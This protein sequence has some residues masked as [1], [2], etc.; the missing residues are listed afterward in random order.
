MCQ[1]LELLRGCELCSRNLSSAASSFHR[2]RK[3]IVFSLYLEKEK[4]EC[5]S[6]IVKR[7]REYLRPVTFLELGGKTN[8]HRALK[9]GNFAK[10]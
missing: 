9:K 6:F 3:D 1:A 2:A 4:T 7:Q 10:W 8:C 5:P